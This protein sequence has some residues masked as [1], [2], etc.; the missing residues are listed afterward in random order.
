MKLVATLLEAGLILLCARGVLAVPPLREANLEGARRLVLFF[1]LGIAVKLALARTAIAQLPAYRPTDLLGFGYLVPSLLAERI[2]GAERAAGGV[3]DRA[4]GGRWRGD[5][6]G[7]ERG[8][9][10]GGAAAGPGLH[11]GLRDAARGG[12]GVAAAAARAG[13]GKGEGGA[14]GRGTGD[15][16][17]L[18]VNER[19]GTLVALRPGRRA[20]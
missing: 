18:V 12:G 11:G 10:V 9:L 19:A 20:C 6:G 7:G 16:Y 13:S 15:G 3:A 2:G 4:R 14:L 5:R 8:A 1:C 17:S